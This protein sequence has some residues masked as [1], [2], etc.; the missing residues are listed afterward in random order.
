[1]GCVSEGAGGLNWALDVPEKHNTPQVREAALPQQGKCLSRLKCGWQVRLC[2]SSCF[3]CKTSYR[4]CKI[5]QGERTPLNPLSSTQKHNENCPLHRLQVWPRASHC[6]AVW[7]DTSCP[8]RRYRRLFSGNIQPMNSDS[9]VNITNE[10]RKI[11]FGGWL[12]PGL[13]AGSR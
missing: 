3:S 7:D 1:M 9:V 13:L 2:L 8:K 11:L 4:S 12:L 10:Y 5:P 6:R